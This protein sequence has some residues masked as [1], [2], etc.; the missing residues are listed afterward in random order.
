PR[1]VNDPKPGR[2]EG[3][4]VAVCDDQNAKNR[5][6]YVKGTHGRVILS[7]L[8]SGGEGASKS[9]ASRGL[10]SRECRRFDVCLPTCSATDAHSSLDC[11]ASSS[12]RASRWRR[13][14]SFGTQ[15]TISR[16]ASPGRS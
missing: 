3:A 13:R 16:A 7:A 5:N 11:C 12:H 2:N 1:L 8:R 10:Y 9:L 15:S 6:D 4:V 14:W